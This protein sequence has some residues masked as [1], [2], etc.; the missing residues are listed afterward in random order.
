MRT[1]GFRD[2]CGTPWPYCAT[3]SGS[4]MG[5]TRSGGDRREPPDP[6]RL[7]HL[8]PE[9]VAQRLRSQCR[10]ETGSR[11]I[12]HAHHRL[13]GSLWHSVAL[14]CDPLRGRT[15]GGTRSG[16]DRREP[17][18]PPPPQPSRP[19]RGRTTTPRNT[20]SGRTHL[21]P[22]PPIARRGRWASRRDATHSAQDF[23]PGCTAYILS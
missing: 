10:S 11:A 2:R 6:P 8:D 15:W 3:P 5:G 23:S 7:N 14:L 12:R 18:E 1:T 13:P 4:D 9:G 22:L 20:H 21:A 19:R 17:P 16:G